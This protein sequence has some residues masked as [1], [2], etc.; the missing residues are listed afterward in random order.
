MAACAADHASARGD[1]WVGT[2]EAAALAVEL[3][4]T[5]PEDISLSMYRGGFFFWVSPR[6]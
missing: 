5:K 2:S 1:S 6:E 3:A 4:V